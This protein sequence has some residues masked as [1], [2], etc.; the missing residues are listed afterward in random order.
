M[1]L[2]N[3]KKFLNEILDKNQLYLSYS[4]I[5]DNTFKVSAEDKRLNKAFY[6]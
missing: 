4:E 2:A 3:Q 6:K 1:E 5:E